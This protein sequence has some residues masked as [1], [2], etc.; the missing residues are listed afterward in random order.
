MSTS[1]GEVP[2]PTKTNN[3]NNGGNDQ[4]SIFL[5]KS[6]SDN[7]LQKKTEK[8]EQN[9]LAIQRKKRMFKNLTNTKVTSIGTTTS[10]KNEK[11]GKIR[12]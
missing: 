9:R 7:N 2:P 10:C 8:I 11:I 4:T 12:K 1:K 5:G 6:E 3:N